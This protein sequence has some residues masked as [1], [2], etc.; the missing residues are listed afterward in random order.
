LCAAAKTRWLPELVGA[1]AIAQYEETAD[2][3]DFADRTK[4]LLESCE[5]RDER[6]K[7]TPGGSAFICA[8][9]EIRGSLLLLLA[10]D[11]APSH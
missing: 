4:V 9:R 10:L 1:T 6:T 5:L 2:Y 8:I 3:A 7:L 11:A